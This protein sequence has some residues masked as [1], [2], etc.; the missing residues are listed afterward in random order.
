M[1]IEMR[2]H[3]YNWQKVLRA[4]DIFCALVTPAWHRDAL[5]QRQY[6]Y[7]RELGKPIILLVKQGTP[8]PAGADDYTWRVWETAEDCAQLIA[9][10]E[11]GALTCPEK[12]IPDA[13]G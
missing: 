2:T 8:L 7:A 1:P 12:E 11:R 10:M 6:A 5:A 3:G 13:H 4:N 9:Q